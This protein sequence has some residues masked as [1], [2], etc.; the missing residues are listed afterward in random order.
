MSEPQPEQEGVA[1]LRGRRMKAAGRARRT[2]PAPL[3]PRPDGVGAGQVPAERTPTEP[4]PAV[5]AD[6]PVSAVDPTA[7]ADPVRISA[8]D[9]A[10]ESGE[11]PADSPDAGVPGPAGPPPVSVP[12]R[13]S[14]ESGTSTAGTAASVRLATSR[15]ISREI[16][17][18]ISREIAAAPE[19]ALPDLWVDTGSALARLPKP[20]T[21]NVPMSIMARFARLRRDADSHTGVVLDALRETVARLP[22]LV[23]EA[24]PQPRTGDLF[25]LRGSGQRERRDPLRIRPTVAE[26]AVIDRIVQWVAEEIDHRYPGSPRVTRSEVVATALDVY[27]PGRRSRTVTGA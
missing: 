7:A 6:E 15:E 8:A 22:E 12:P 1:G 11:E 13:A 16:P 26:L 21:M 24:R 10:P 19:R 20:T 2:P 23:A 5:E 3:H 27:L 18:E 25:P 4:T 14:G 9:A 17:R